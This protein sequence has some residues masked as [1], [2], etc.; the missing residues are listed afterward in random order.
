M[1]N[2]KKK[3]E[4]AQQIK[5]VNSELSN[6]HYMIGHRN[7][8]NDFDEIL[9][10][11][12]EGYEV[13]SREEVPYDTHSAY[14]WSTTW[15]LVLINYARKERYDALKAELKELEKEYHSSGADFCPKLDP[16]MVTFQSLI[17]TLSGGNEVV[18][19]TSPQ[20]FMFEVSMNV[21]DIYLEEGYYYIFPEYT[22]EGR[23]RDKTSI[24]FNIRNSEL[25]DLLTNK[26]ELHD[27]FPDAFKS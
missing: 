13:L 8:D 24:T 17:P 26:A 22:K 15:E 19:F 21:T 12:P 6:A 2:Y 11:L 5:D 10:N 1:E 7:S 3:Q 20:G 9:S 16:S 14:D 4:L 23:V 25:H 18:A 27:I